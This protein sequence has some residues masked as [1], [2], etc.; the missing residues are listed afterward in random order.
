VAADH[1]GFTKLVVADLDKCAAFYSQVF[2]VKEQYRVHADICGREIDEILFEATAPG[3]ASFVL[4]RFAGAI[5]PSSEEVILGFIADDVDA[6]C[7]RVAE[8]GGSVAQEAREQPEHGVKVAFVTDVENHLI[9]VV[10]LL[11]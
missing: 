7:A 10:Q 6:V 4:L 2:G 3:G 8:A 11:A 5:S 9:E 1:F